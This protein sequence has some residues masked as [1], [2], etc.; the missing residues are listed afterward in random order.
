M[1]TSVVLVCG[2]G[3]ADGVAG[4]L[5]KSPGTAVVGHEFDGHVVRR[6]VS[7]LSHGELSTSEVALELRKGCVSC[8][9]R[10]DL[11]ILLRRMHRRDDVE[12]IVVLLAPWMEPEPICYAINHVRVRVGTGYIDG[13]AARDVEIRAV[14]ACIDADT[15]LT[16]ALG[17]EELND[18]RT[19]AQVVVGQAEFADAVVLTEPERTTLAVL[20]RLTPRARITVGTRNLEMALHHLDPHGRRGA[21]ADPHE[22]LLAGQPPLTPEGEVTLV[23]FSAHRP[24]HPLRPHSA[25]DS[26][27]DGVVRARGRLWL[28]S[29]PDNVVWIESAGGGLRVANAGTWLAAMSSSDLAYAG[30][31]R[32][33]IASAHWDHDHGDRH[34]SMTILV[35]GAQP[36]EIINALQKALLTDDEFSRPEGW[37][38]YDD[39]FGDWHEDPCDSTPQSLDGISVRGAHE[40]DDT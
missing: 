18:G 15:W 39:P 7:I 6:W 27:L 40:G 3:E 9:V 19:V 36:G 32:Q 26:L 5:M 25:I 4:T 12:R 17:D 30:H 28:A 35:C 2:Q 24:F 31:E 33:A 29:K 10:N 21:D 11:L 16:Q 37:S 23:E 13:P 38:R 22:P 20:K 14:V 1:R 8:T 34:V